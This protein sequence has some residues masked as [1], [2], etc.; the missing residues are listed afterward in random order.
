MLLARFDSVRAESVAEAEQTPRHRG[1]AACA[2]Q[3]RKGDAATLEE[4]S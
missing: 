4:E 1:D 3:A 2:F